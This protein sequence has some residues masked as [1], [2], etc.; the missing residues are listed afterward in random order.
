MRNAF[1]PVCALFMLCACLAS[2][3]TEE[4]ERSEHA[5]FLAAPQPNLPE[6]EDLPDCWWAEDPDKCEYRCGEGPR[7]PPPVRVLPIT[8]AKSGATPRRAQQGDDLSIKQPDPCPDPD[9]VVLCPHCNRL[10]W[11]PTLASFEVHSAVSSRVV[12]ANAGGAFRVVSLPGLG[13]QV[14]AS[15]EPGVEFEPAVL[16]D[17]SAGDIVDEGGNLS[18]AQDLFLLFSIED[19]ATAVPASY[20]VKCPASGAQ[21]KVESL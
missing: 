13:S 2:P 18:F 11:Q 9:G 12:L 15:V 4:L 8:L 3:H 1:L 17:L 5:L 6:P 7:R 19:D 20:W 14:A 16:L 21:C 10:P